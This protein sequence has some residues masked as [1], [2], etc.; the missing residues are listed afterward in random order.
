MTKPD[1]TPEQA[2]NLD[3]LATHLEGLPENYEWFNMSTFSEATEC[4][5]VACACGHGP[6]AGIERK[7]DESWNDYADRVFG[8]SPDSENGYFLFDAYWFWCQPT[9]HQAAARIRVF[10]K[11]GIPEAFSGDDI[12]TSYAQSLEQSDD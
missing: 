7:G 3:K 11:G 8:V 6:L 5:T 1:I 4:G 2:D 9:H 10:L 12:F